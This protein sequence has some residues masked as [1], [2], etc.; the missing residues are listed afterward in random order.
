V[1]DRQRDGQTDRIPIDNARSAAPAGRAVL[2]NKPGYWSFNIHWKIRQTPC[3]FLHA[4]H[5]NKHKYQHHHH[6]HGHYRHKPGS[7]VSNIAFNNAVLCVNKCS[8]F[9]AAF[10]DNKGLSGTADII[11]S[12]RDSAPHK[13]TEI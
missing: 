5:A 3:S 9:R 11:T 2:R 6:C 1:T 10:R 12:A 7:Y 13:Q 4:I 8:V